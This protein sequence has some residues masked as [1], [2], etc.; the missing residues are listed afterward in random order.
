MAGFNAR[1]KGM[2][3]ALQQMTIYCSEEAHSSIQKAVDL[4]GFGSDSL[5]RVPVNKSMQ[6]NLAA[7]KAK[8]KRDRASGH[9]AI[10]VVGIAGTTNTGSID[11]LNALADI[12][13]EEK[14][15]FHV[16]GAF[17]AWVAIAPKFKYLVVR[18]ERADSLVFGLHK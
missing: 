3:D 8:I 11:D 5:R 4:L 6:I 9:L 16:D 15:W 2:F 13:G 14:C 12:C 10:Y 17:G 1:S 18:M 7:L